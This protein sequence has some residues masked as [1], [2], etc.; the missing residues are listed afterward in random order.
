[1][2]GFGFNLLTS[3]FPFMFIGVF[4]FVMFMFISTFIKGAKQSKINRNSPVLDVEAKVVAK[5]MAVRGDHSHTY[6]Y[7]T[8]E[9]PSG[10]RMELHVQGADYGMMVEG[11]N[12]IL[13]FR[14][15]EY[16]GF[17]RK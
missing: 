6:Y 3:I 11:D 13:R 10:D 9:V 5:R 1:M 8:F 2:S 12:G 4:A 17:T 14:G 16:L 7:V 15:N